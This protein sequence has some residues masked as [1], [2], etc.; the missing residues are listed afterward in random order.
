MKKRA[1][2]QMGL[3][4]DEPEP[5]PVKPKPVKPDNRWTMKASKEWLRERVNRGVTCP[6]CGQLAKVYKR[7]LNGA[8]ALVLIRMASAPL[9]AMDGLGYFHVPSYLNNCGLTPEVAA[10]VRGDWAKLVHWDLIEAAPKV[11]EDGS[12][13]TGEWRLTQLGIAFVNRQVRVLSHLRIY[14]GSPLGLTGK[15]VWITEVLGDGF[16]YE[17]LMKDAS[18]EPRLGGEDG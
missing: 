8:M 16:S 18:A 12:S 14:D 1:K 2:Q 7:P 5:A 17:E 6:C 4:G 11:R 13:R 10:A 15:Y 9:E 3:F